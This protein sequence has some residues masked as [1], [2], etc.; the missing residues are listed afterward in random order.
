MVSTLCIHVMAFISASCKLQST[1]YITTEDGKC[2]KQALDP[3]GMSD[4]CIPG[5]AGE[6][7]YC[8]AEYCMADFPV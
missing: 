4:R 7:A 3:N 2:Y 1:N 5:R 6:R 8:I